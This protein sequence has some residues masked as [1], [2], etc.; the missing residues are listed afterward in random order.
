MII[1]DLYKNVANGITE[2]FT[3]PAVELGKSSWKQSIL[4]SCAMKIK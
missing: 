1:T 2:S 3:N 4:M